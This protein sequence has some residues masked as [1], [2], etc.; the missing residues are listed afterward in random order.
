MLHHAVK[1]WC[2]TIGHT[3]RRRMHSEISVSNI[4]ALCNSLSVDLH[5]V[6]FDWRI[7]REAQLA[8]LKWSS[9]S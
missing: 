5:T 6:V 1:P 2:T 4:R 7:I 3:C 8:L 9:I